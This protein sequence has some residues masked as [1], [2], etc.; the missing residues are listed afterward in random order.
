MEYIDGTHNQLQL[1]VNWFI[2]IIEQ[3][4][5]QLEPRRTYYLRYNAI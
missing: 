5:A 2:S 4:Q 3:W 1:S